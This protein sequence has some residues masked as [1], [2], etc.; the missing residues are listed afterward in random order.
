MYFYDV[1][2]LAALAGAVAMMFV[3]MAWYSKP[4]FGKQF[5]AFNNL[6]E[7]DVKN[8]PKI[9]FLYGFLNSIVTSFMLAFFL[10]KLGANNTSSVVT[11]ALLLWLGLS[12]T[13]Q[14][15]PWIW[16]RQ[17]GQLTLINVSHQGTGILCSALVMNLF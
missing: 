16:E 4:M 3:G 15:L 14:L 10:Q 12:A 9:M 2:L 13:T 17:N 1:N 11:T 8:G 5:L 6:T 7:E